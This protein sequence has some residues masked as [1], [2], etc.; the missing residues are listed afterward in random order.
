MVIALDRRPVEIPY[1]ENGLS[2]YELL[3]G[4]YEGGIRNFRCNLKA[5]CTYSPEMYADKVVVL[6]FGKGRAYVTDA[7]GAWNVTELA[8][9]FPNFDKTPYVVHAIDDMEFIFSVVDMNEWD[10]QVYNG[11]HARL[12]LFRTISKCVIYDQDCKGPQTD[13]Y[14]VLRPCQ[15]G[16]IL[17]GAVKATGDGTREKGHPCVAQWNYCVGNSDFNLSVEDETVST[18][19]G[20]WSYVVAGKDHSLVSEPGKE[21]YYVWY[22]HFVREKDFL[23]KPL[24]K[25]FRNQ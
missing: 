16:R 6:M 25:R 5:G 24:A 19:A 15:L 8:F 1:D 3:A 23:I 18:V 14:T 13:S 2:R 9:Y 22:E 17:I 4:T 11:S 7:T 12:P 20:D 21:A 10:W